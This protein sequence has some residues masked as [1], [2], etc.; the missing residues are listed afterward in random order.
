MNEKYSFSDFDFSLEF[1]MDMGMLVYGAAAGIDFYVTESLYLT[2]ELGYRL[3]SGT[4][5]FIYEEDDV[6]E[7]EGLDFSGNS[8]Y[9][10]FGVLY[11]F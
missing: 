2:A 6:K 3:I 4:G 10:A 11:R 9:L 8:P 5:D 7:K 1:E